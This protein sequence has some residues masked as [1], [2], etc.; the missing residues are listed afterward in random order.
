MLEKY[1]IPI[2]S[3]ERQEDH[4][5]VFGGG[6]VLTANPEPFAP[7]FDIILLGDGE[8]LIPQFIDQL[9]KIKNL[10]RENQLIELTQIDGIYAP[11]LYSP[12]YSKEG[13]LLDIEPIHANIPKFINKQT[14]R[15]R[16]LCHSS[17]ITPNSAW[18]NIHMVEMVR[19]CPELCRFC[20]ASYLTLPFRTASLEDNLI[21]AVEKGLHYTNRIGLLG[22]SITQHPEFTELLNWFNQDRLNHVRL[23]ISSV[24]ANTV[25]HEMMKL[26]QKRGCKSITIAIESGSQRIRKLI[27]K[28]L[29]EEEI[30][31][32]ARYTHEA[33]L[34]SLKLYGMVGLPTEED[35]DIDATTDLLIKLKKKINSLKLIL[36]V[37]TFVPKA[38]TP[39]QWIGVN[40]KSKKRIKLITKRLHSN[41]IETRAESYGLSMVQ[42]LISRS[43]RRLA[44]VI[45]EIRK[46]PNQNLGNWKKI[47]LSAFNGELNSHDDYISSIKIPSWEEIIFTSWDHKQILPW[48][49]IQ[50][51]LTIEQLIKHKEESFKA[52]AVESLN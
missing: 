31:S 15:G 32:A 24:R 13:N 6:P 2:W 16:A 9:Q 12:K 11:N 46:H 4:P 27:N 26:L 47:Y 1:H 21:P 23:S 44:P 35:V 14:W 33:G 20:L 25:S 36:G 22:A 37:S 29:S 39:F 5:I 8:E 41:G 43:D 28:K 18:P 52:G 38:H 7:F 40:N 3:R 34:K 42:A 45:A 48:Q 30:F 50:G 51:P 17:V 49:H 10:S 19:S